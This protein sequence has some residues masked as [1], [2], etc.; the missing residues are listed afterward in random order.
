MRSSYERRHAQH[1]TT[2]ITALCSAHNIRHSLE[3]LPGDCA[4]DAQALQHRGQLAV[5]QG[6]APSTAVPSQGVRPARQSRHNVGASVMN[7]HGVQGMPRKTQTVHKQGGAEALL[8]CRHVWHVS[9]PARI[10]KA[11]ALLQANHLKQLYER[12]RIACAQNAHT[13]SSISP[14]APEDQNAAWLGVPYLTPL[15]TESPLQQLCLP[16]IDQNGPRAQAQKLQTSR[17]V[18]VC[19]C[20]GV[21]R[22]RS[23]AVAAKNQSDERPG[24]FVTCTVAWKHR[25]QAQSA[26]L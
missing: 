12:V 7:V 17:E 25:L 23:G 6:G 5:P 16:V 20:G 2:S 8:R 4:A 22:V 24:P 15:G 26:V 1:F 13:R 14:S 11:T 19:E 9:A 18:N 3:A 10:T 21:F